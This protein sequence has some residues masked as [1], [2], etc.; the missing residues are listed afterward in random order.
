MQFVQAPLPIHDQEAFQS[1]K[2][3]ITSGLERSRVERFLKS[4]GHGVQI[5]DFEK[6]AAAGLL[7]QP[8]QQAKPLYD[9][10]NVT[11]KAQIREIYLTV[12][13][14]IDPELRKKYRKLF[15]YS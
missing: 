11:D 7:D 12:V 1:L 4:L 10:M 6:V 13:E 2:G 14:E 3:L 8:G 9:A 5:R 15:R